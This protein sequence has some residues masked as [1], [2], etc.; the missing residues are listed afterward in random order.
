MPITTEK[1]EAR[2]KRC[3]FCGEETKK[4]KKC[5]LC[6]KEGCGKGEYRE[7]FAFILQ[8]SR[9]NAE[10]MEREVYICRDCECV[11]RIEEVTNGTVTLGDFLSALMKG[12]EKKP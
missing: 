6:G 3:D 11:Q 1:R 7:H 10:D 5:V 8:I 9:Y 4:V 12:A 2:V